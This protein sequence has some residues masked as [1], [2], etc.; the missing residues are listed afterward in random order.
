MD[1]D[2]QQDKVL[3]EGIIISANKD[4]LAIYNKKLE[5]WPLLDNYIVSKNEIVKQDEKESEAKD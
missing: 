1:R 4:R 5:I 3:A 2:K